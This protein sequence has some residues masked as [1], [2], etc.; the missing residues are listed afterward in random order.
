MI[1][2][3]DIFFRTIR[4]LIKQMSKSTMVVRVIFC[5]GNKAAPQLKYDSFAFFPHFSELIAK[6]STLTRIGHF[7]FT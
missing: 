5:S 1:V 2:K 3:T 6:I 7:S 4:R